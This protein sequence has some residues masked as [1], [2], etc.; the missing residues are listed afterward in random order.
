VRSRSN[1]TATPLTRRA[2][3][4]K[5][6]ERRLRVRLTTDLS[7]YHAGL[8]VGAEGVTVGAAGTWSRGSDRFVGVMF[9]GIGALRT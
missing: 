1:L 5:S 9:P 4:T 6:R 3:T 7:R 2:Y 8:T